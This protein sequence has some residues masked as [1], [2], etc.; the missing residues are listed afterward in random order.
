M[1]QNENKHSENIN[2]DHL[3]V[4]V[5][6][7]RVYVQNTAEENLLLNRQVDDLRKSNHTLNGTVH[8]LRVQ[9]TSVESQKEQTIARMW[10]DRE[11]QK[12][13]TKE[14]QQK[15]EKA[16]QIIR[17]QSGQSEKP[18]DGTMVLY[19]PQSQSSKQKAGTPGRYDDIYENSPPPFDLA[20]C[21]TPTKVH[22]HQTMAYH[23]QTTPQQGPKSQKPVSRRSNPFDDI[24]QT[25]FTGSISAST[26]GITDPY[27]S[28]SPIGCL[29]NPYA[30]RPESSYQNTIPTQSFTLASQPSYVPPGFGESLSL[31]LVGL[32]KTVEE[33]SK[34]YCNVPDK[35]RDA[36]MP[37][38]VRA[39]LYKTTNHTQAARLIATSKTRYFAVTKLILYGIV[40]FAFQPKCV[41]GLS[42]DFDL[43]I[44]TERSKLHCG[45]PSYVRD[46]VAHAVVSIVGEMKGHPNWSS[47]LN[48]STE[49]QAHH[50]WKT[51]KPLVAAAADMNAAYWGLYGI[52]KEAMRI[53]VT[54]LSTPSTFESNFPA[55]GD[56]SAFNPAVMINRELAFFEYDPRT[57]GQMN[58]RVR[59]GITPIVSEIKVEP[60]MKVNVKELTFALVLLMQ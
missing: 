1:P 51:V 46:T 31:P 11:K 55:V 26:K 16:Q 14:L 17:Y 38:N 34:R 37:D 47:H 53:G 32:F 10:Q 48:Q 35:Q 56:D 42:P 57:L 36:E 15:L 60:S 58:L 5:N 9:L 41:R 59:L 25:P 40:D 33:W 18:K 13:M 7:Q 8:N 19:T 6:Q 43:R 45:V 30:S 24:F 2:V 4:E 50:Q 12:A 52:W 3:L 27:L 29:P 39:Q 49:F 23:M 28:S 20:S 44:F 21:K 54:M 22:P